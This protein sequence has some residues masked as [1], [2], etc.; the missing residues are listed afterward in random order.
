MS[1]YQERLEQD[2]EEI[3]NRTAAVGASVEA[4]FRQAIHAVL[5]NDSELSSRIVL[6][7]L[8][9]NREVREIDQLCHAFVARHLPSAGHLRFVS[10]ALR[11]NI[12]LERIGDYAV[13]IAREQVQLSGPPPER[14]ARDIELIAEQTTLMLQQALE[15]FNKRNA[16]LARG[17][18]PMGAQ[19]E[20]TFEKVF[21]DLLEEGESDGPPLRD[22]FATLVILNRIGRVAD[23][24]K[25]ICEET[26]FVVTGETK[27]PKVYRVLFL[28]ERGDSLA[29]IAAAYAAKAFPNSGQFSSAGW[30]AAEAVDPR[31]RAVADR[32]GLDLGEQA[33]T[34][35]DTIRDE[36]DDVHVIV[37]FQSGAKAHLGAV[38]FHTTLLHWQLPYPAADLD[39][40][41]A[42]ATYDEAL[43]QLS[44]EIRQLMHLLRGKEAN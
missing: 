2:L 12:A 42:E 3:R 4:A 5:I 31:A 44:V 25:N 43:K 7:D 21:N 14:F 33:P 17:T 15:A 26:V 18:K 40:Q 9:I 35:L 38:P 19:I 24:S 13:T 41:R 8:P 22:L 1:H 10:S 29:P 32:N 27:E 36:V 30:A 23:Q 34:P 37:S 28:D 6:R 20:G 16:E 39:Q 11:M